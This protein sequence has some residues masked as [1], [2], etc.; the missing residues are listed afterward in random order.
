MTETNPHVSASANQA[1]S[2]NGEVDEQELTSDNNVSDNIKY[3]PGLE[4]GDLVQ[5]SEKNLPKK[6]NYSKM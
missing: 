6:S 5:V 4:M 2:S 1:F 3:A